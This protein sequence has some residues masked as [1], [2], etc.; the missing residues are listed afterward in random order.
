MVLIREHSP[1]RKKLDA[2]RHH[3]RRRHAELKQCHHDRAE[4][5]RA[6]QRANG[7]P[8]EKSPL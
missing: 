4:F 5:K 3:N 7:L 6:Q 8:P 1:L 2:N